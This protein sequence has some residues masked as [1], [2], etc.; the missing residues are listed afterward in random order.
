ML[1]PK[2]PFPTPKYFPFQPA[3]GIQTSN[4]TWESLDG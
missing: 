1:P 2:P 4:S 3:I